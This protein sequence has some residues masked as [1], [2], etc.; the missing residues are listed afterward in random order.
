MAA[1][2][3]QPSPRRRSRPEPEGL[4][5]V[6]ATRDKLELVWPAVSNVRSWRVVCWDGKDKAV[7]LLTL[8]SEHRRATLRRARPL[9]AAIH[10][11]RLWPGQRSSGDL[12]R[13]TRRPHTE[14]QRSG[15]EEHHASEE[16]QESREREDSG[17]RQGEAEEEDLAGQVV[18]GQADAGGGE[19][20]VRLGRWSRPRRMN[21]SIRAGRVMDA[22]TGCV[23][24]KAS[25]SIRGRSDSG[26]WTGSGMARART[27]RTRLPSAHAA[28]AAS[29]S[30]SA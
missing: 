4:Q 24:V 27:S 10:R 15:K 9:E 1:P 8:S 7:A 23:D 22:R 18:A 12:A 6:R 25:L 14:R 5:L 3:Q 21:R 20:Q 2:R 30:C 28:L 19:L 11:R 16:D 29:G 26:E 17:H 13:R